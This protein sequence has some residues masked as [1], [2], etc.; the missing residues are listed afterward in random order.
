MLNKDS[1][2]EPVKAVIFD[3]GKV[4]IDFNFDLAFEAASRIVKLPAA[5]IRRRLFG[6]EGGRDL[7]EFECGRISE[8]E[9]HR[10]VEMTLGQP[11]PYEAFHELWNCIFL[12]EIKPTVAILHQLRQQHRVSVGI[13]SNINVLH[14]DYLRQRMNVLSQVQHV[15]ASHEI[16]CRKPDV[17]SFDYVL[18]K[19]DVAPQQ[20][21]LIDDLSDNVLAAESIGMRIIHATHPEAVLSGLQ[22]LGFGND[23]NA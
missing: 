5:E 17:A 8:H 3:I 13:L 15:Y 10:R 12:E 16:G 20:A 18:K 7:V 11:L 6:G 21:V 2:R 22:A 9:Y 4:L 23:L 19:M 14:F 1:F